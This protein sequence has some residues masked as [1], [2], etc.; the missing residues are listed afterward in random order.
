MRSSA[1]DAIVCQLPKSSRLSLAGCLRSI[2]LSFRSVS[3]PWRGGCREQ[4]RIIKLSL[5]ISGWIQASGLVMASSVRCGMSGIETFSTKNILLNEGPLASN[6]HFQG[7]LRIPL[8]VGWM[9][10]APS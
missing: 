5:N 10:L 8:L 2:S 9:N 4:H 1:S 3:S 7:S 6:R